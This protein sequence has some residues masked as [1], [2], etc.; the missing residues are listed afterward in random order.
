MRRW[1]RRGV[2]DHHHYGKDDL[3]QALL[4]YGHNV[5]ISER[6]WLGPRRSLHM[7]GE[8]HI[9]ASLLKGTLPFG[10]NAF[11][12][13]AIISS[14][15]S[16]IVRLALHQANANK[17]EVIFSRVGSTE[18]GPFDPRTASSSS[19]RPRVL[20]PRVSRGRLQVPHVWAG[21]PLLRAHGSSPSTSKF[22]SFGIFDTTNLWSSAKSSPVKY[23]FWFVWTPDSVLCQVLRCIR[24]Q[25]LEHQA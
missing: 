19:I 11:E 5:P 8:R 21:R 17:V 2:V 4:E 1:R 13:V 23:C 15:N 12:A 7:P 9:K 24:I 22:E 3:R 16:R 14:C 10:L 20:T 6:I 25:T 18:L